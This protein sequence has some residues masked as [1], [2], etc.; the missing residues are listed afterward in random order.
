MQMLSAD[1]EREVKESAAINIKP[2]E[3][4]EDDQR[5][6]GGVSYKFNRGLQLIIER[7]R[8]S[9]IAERLTEQLLEFRDKNGWI[10]AVKND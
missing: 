3:I 2:G 8:I 9:I 7:E 1:L 10:Q 6:I 4:L 5:L